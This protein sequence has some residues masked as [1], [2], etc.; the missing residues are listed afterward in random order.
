MQA[1]RVM[2]RISDSKDA[3]GEDGEGEQSLQGVE[4]QGLYLPASDSLIIADL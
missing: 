2:S 1:G 4:T 3:G